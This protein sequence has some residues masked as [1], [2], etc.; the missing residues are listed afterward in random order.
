MQEFGSAGYETPMGLTPTTLKLGP[1]GPSFKVGYLGKFDTKFE[2][3]LEYE[4]LAHI[5]SI[6]EKR[7]DAKY[8]A[9]L[10]L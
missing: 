5:V 2:N 4:S 10:S 3:I 1:A 7:L 9:L 6:Q 8:L